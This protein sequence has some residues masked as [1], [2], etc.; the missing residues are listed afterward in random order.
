MDITTN[1]VIPVGSSTSSSISTALFKAA[2][3]NGE[4]ILKLGA[5]AFT[6][7]L[8]DQGGAG[9]GGRTPSAHGVF[10]KNLWSLGHL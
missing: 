2:R 3:A 4:S 10:T 6:P 7:L 5:Q 1:E 8:S 9:F